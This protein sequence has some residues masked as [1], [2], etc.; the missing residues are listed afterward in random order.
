MTS[1]RLI[2]S[3]LS[4]GYA[5]SLL[6]DNFS[7]HSPS[8]VLVFKGP[9]GSGKTTLLKLMFGWLKP[10]H[11]AVLPPHDRAALVLQDD[12]LFPWL[13]GRA[14]ITRFIQIEPAQLESHPLF[15]VVSEF[16]DRRAYAMSFG[17]RRSIELLRMIL[18]KPDILYLDE[19][20]NYLDDYKAQR[21]IDFITRNEVSNLLIVTTHR[22]DTALDA[23][24]DVFHFTGI[25]PY[26]GLARKTT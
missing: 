19:P 22:N 24:A 8:R 4:F 10:S 15:P 16:I 25:Q 11:P 9:S 21:F 7:L 23:V 13:S 17:Q 3:D 20:F 2:V 6:F 12:A 18:L 5:D 26:R 1:D 14:N